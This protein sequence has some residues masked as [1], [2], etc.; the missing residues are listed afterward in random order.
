[1]RSL[2]VILLVA[3]TCCTAAAQTPCEAP[4]ARQLDFWLG[5]WELNWEGGSGTHHISRLFDEG[6]TWEP[7][8]VIHYER[9][10]RE[11]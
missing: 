9:S 5:T 6:E 4:E 11:R 8:W 3:T 7:T 2:F 10:A 1:M